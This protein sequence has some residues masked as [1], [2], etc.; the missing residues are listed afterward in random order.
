MKIKFK[1]DKQFSMIKNKTVAKKSFVHISMTS[2][3]RNSYQNLLIK[4]LN[5]SASTGSINFN[6]LMRL[7][8]ADKL[9]F[10]SI[11]DDYLGF[12]FISL[13]RSA[14]GKRTSGIFVRTL[15]CYS[16]KR[17]IHFVKKF[18]FSILRRIPNI[19]L[20]SIVPYHIDIRISK[21]SND[22]IYDPQLWD[23]SYLG[24][25][26]EI[27]L[28]DLSS[29]I[30]RKKGNRKVVIFIGRA[31]RE[32]G[33]FDLYEFMTRFPDKLLVV[34]GKIA[35]DCT[36]IAE[37]FLEMGMIVHNRWVSDEEI[38]SIYRLADYAWCSYL[39]EYD[40]PSGVYGRAVQMKVMPI[41]RKN[42][43][44]EKLSL[45]LGVAYITKNNEFIDNKYKSSVDIKYLENE[46]ILKIRNSTVTQCH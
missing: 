41:I 39:P 33:F 42:S 9:F 7:I 17:P 24:T 13:I 43:F 34:A 40:Q 5:F 10:A 23:L 37:K 35:D 28:T 21:I 18:I 27:I 26:N 6:S 31:T 45:K 29:E 16:G 44:L 32:K 15:Q 30:Q 3:H 4:I 46:S 19:F 38:L 14:A 2:G 22:W 20:L 8:N 25:D 36:Y 11:D 12:I 1:D